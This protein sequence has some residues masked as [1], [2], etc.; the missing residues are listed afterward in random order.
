MLTFKQNSYNPNLN[1]YIPPAEVG[2]EITLKLDMKDGCIKIG[3]NQLIDDNNNGI[4]MRGYLLGYQ[5]YFGDVG[6]YEDAY[7]TK[8]LYIPLVN[9]PLL[10]FKKLTVCS[11][12]CRGDSRKNFTKAISIAPVQDININ[13]SVTEIKFDKVEKSTSDGQKVWTRPALFSF[14]KPTE[15]EISIIK[16]ILK[17]LSTEEAELLLTQLVDFSS[18][19]NVILLSGENDRAKITAFKEA[20]ALSAPTQNTTYALPSSIELSN[21]SNSIF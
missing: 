11:I 10:S 7:W 17:E 5:N 2:Q 9:H 12:W 6:M 16:T 21:N 20:K 4:I 8:L 15:K 3:D 13:H 18:G 19:N 1:V 14:V